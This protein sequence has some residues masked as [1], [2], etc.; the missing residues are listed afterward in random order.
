[1]MSMEMFESKLIFILRAVARVRAKNKS[2]LE[3]L[4]CT[5]ARAKYELVLTN[6]VQYIRVWYVRTLSVS[7]L[8][9]HTNTVYL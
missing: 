1:M 5:R 3:R 6:I 9:L 2:L 8:R 4:G 7:F